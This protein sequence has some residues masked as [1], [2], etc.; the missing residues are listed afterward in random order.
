MLTG[1]RYIVLWF[2][3]KILKLS[4]VCKFGGLMIAS[5]KLDVL[6]D[7]DEA[8]VLPTATEVGVDPNGVLA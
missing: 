6:S 4:S 5:I 2:R 8:F 3:N 7:A 1:K